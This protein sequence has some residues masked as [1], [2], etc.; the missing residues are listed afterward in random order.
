MKVEVLAGWQLADAVGVGVDAVC[1]SVS[2]LCRDHAG[3]VQ[4]FVEVL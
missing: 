2:M 3:G 4:L 1:Q